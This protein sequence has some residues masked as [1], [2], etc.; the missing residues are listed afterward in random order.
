MNPEIQ[1]KLEAF[2]HEYPLVRMRK[3]Q[4]V[5]AG[6][7]EI[8]D[9]FWI[10]RG[11]IRMYQ[12]SEDGAEITLHYFKEPAF[13][14]IMFYLSH[15]KGDNYHFQAVDEVIA[16]RAPA[17]EVVTYLK[18]NPDVLFDLTKRFADAI[19]GLLLRIEQLSSLKTYERVAAL[20]EYLAD[21]FGREEGSEL[22]IDLKL[23]HDDLAAW[24]G[25]A[26]ETVSHQIEKMTHE[27]IIT[28]RDRKFIV[29]DRERLATISK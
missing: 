3:G 8:E 20:L 29:L 24:V 21:K 22:I 28:S 6:E 9:I 27:G 11:M 26:R 17:Q 13:F 12:I 16:R 2:F 15:R 25:A 7:D 4:Q 23:S 14:P 5:S 10:R 19:T 18:N 1:D